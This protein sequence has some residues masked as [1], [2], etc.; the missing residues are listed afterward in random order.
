MLV[1]ACDHGYK[2]WNQIVDWLANL[3]HGFN[4]RLPVLEFLHPGYGRIKGDLSGVSF[5]RSILAG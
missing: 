5:F 4:I 1:C 2:K 3:S